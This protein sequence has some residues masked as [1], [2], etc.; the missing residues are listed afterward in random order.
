MVRK[1]PV[2]MVIQSQE[3]AAVVASG[4]GLGGL[5]RLLCALLVFS[6]LI[7]VSQGPPQGGASQ[8]QNEEKEARLTPALE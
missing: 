5:G 2:M 3:D 8:M 7:P 6:H 1:M 4:V